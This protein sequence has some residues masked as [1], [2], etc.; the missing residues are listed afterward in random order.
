MTQTSKKSHSVKKNNFFKISNC[1]S[2]KTAYDAL[3]SCHI[4]RLKQELCW[5]IFVWMFLQCIFFEVLWNTLFCIWNIVKEKWVYVTKL[6]VYC[7]ESLPIEANSY[8]LWLAPGTKHVN[9][10]GWNIM[11][12]NQGFWIFPIKRER[13]VK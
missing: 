8:L 7:E 9:Q 11:G 4:A 6:S 12:W 3:C 10:Q 13:F 1:C 2:K 5:Y